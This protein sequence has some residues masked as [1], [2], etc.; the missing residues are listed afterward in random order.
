MTANASLFA[1]LADAP[2][3]PVLVV[4]DV[5]HAAPLAD[6][7]AEG[8]LA[9]VEVT[10]RTANALDVMREMKSAQPD[11]FVGAGTVTTP[12]HVDACLSVGADFLVSPGLTPAL[13]D[14]FSA[15]GVPCMPGIAS[16][17]EAMRAFDEGFADLKFFPAEAAGGA[18]F[19][20]AISAPLPHIRFMPTGGLTVSNVGDYL[21]LDSVFAV[22]GSWIAKADDLTSGNW[23][24]ITE[25]AIAATAL[26]R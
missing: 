2:V 16:A 5:A 18:P 13:V 12:A 19:L 9:A 4:E 21:A 8:G 10:L 14:A 7:L 15:S 23:S 24:G 11:L 17:S 25:R 22:G 6:A 26:K 3:V 1:R 20:K